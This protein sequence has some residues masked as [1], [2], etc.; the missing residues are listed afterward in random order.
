V[1]IHK[2]HLDIAGPTRHPA[3][4]VVPVAMLV[5]VAGA[6]SAEVGPR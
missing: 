2:G 6:V 5:H 3:D 1:G 4:V